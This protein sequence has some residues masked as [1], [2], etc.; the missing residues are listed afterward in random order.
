[1]FKPLV[2]SL[3]IMFLL[4]PVIAFAF[5]W[6][7]YYAGQNVAN[8][9]RATAPVVPTAADQ[10]YIDAKVHQG[11][12]AKWKYW[13]EQNKQIGK[14]P[15]DLQIKKMQADNDAA[16]RKLD[17]TLA[18]EYKHFYGHYPETYKSTPCIPEDG[19][20]IPDEF[21]KPATK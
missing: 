4:N 8:A 6:G 18:N 9:I 12:E 7:A 21:L 14:T 15:L 10:A 11:M 17:Q 3:S 1:M 2:L 13:E 19:P 20:G 16:N 5:D